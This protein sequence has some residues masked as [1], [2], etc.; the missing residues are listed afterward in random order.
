MWRPT[1][2]L[3]RKVVLPSIR[4]NASLGQINFSTKTRPSSTAKLT[5]VSASIGVL[6]GVGYGGYTHYKVNNKKLTA[7][8]EN[9]AFLKELPN[10]KPHYKVN[11]S[12]FLTIYR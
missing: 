4:E 11:T 9:N 6:V 8:A 12:N 10:Y 3:I 5:L 2:T 7:P 1:H